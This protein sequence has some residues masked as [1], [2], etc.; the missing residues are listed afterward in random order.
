[1]SNADSLLQ[2]AIKKEGSSSKGGLSSF[3]G[4]GRSTSNLEE[5]RDLYVNAANA[6]K[7]DK[8]FKESGDAFARAGDCAIKAGE[9]DDA[10]N[11]YWNAAKSYK[12]THPECMHLSLS[13]L[14]FM[15]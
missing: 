13:F 9:K 10:A 8:R 3:F 4:G 15:L 6:Y 14:L 5:A 2:Q 7:L 12:K 11:D 1:M